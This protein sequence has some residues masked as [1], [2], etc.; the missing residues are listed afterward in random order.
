[1]TPLFVLVDPMAGEPLSGMGAPGTA[2]EAQALREQ[3]W[4]REIAPVPLAGTI[5]L[6]PRQ[7]PY[8]VQLRGADDPLLEATLELAEEE[9]LAAQSKG[10]D[11]EGRAVHRIGG[12]LQSSMHFEQLGARLS[13]LCRV[14][15]DAYTKAT[16]L[17]LADRRA[18]D[19]LCHVAGE[20]RVASQLGRVQS[21]TYLDAFGALRRLRSPGELPQPLR[22]DA[23]EW[24]RMEGGEMLH[25]T[26]AQWLGELSR[27]DGA[28]PRELYPAAGGAVS[29]AAS[30]ARKW[31]HR[32]Q[33][34]SDQVVWATLSLLHPELA[35]LPGVQ[36]LLDDQGTQDE[37]PEPLRYLHRDLDAIALRAG[38]A[39]SMQ[40]DRNSGTSW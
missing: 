22:L 25:R 14:N 37:P 8:L 40:I 36:A 24:R 30:A 5:A 9:R 33:N 31:P 26:I 15:T 20:H 27:K 23:A 28:T 13:A 18:L 11:G 6:P 21:W 19:L 39:K 29:E 2:A 32:F 34:S 1:M 16:Y 38:A 4:D 10:L 3:A 12:W 7:H 35:R 17:R